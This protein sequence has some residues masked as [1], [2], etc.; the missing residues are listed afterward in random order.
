MLKEIGDVDGIQV[1]LINLGSVHNK[2]EKYSESIKLT[3]R[4]IAAAKRMKDGLA[5]IRGYQIMAEIFRKQKDFKS[6]VMYQLIYTKFYE[7][8]YQR[9]DRQQVCE[10]EHQFTIQ[11]LEKRIAD[12]Q[13]NRHK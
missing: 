8:F 5:E 9:N 6:A 11:Q 3:S 10:I 2:L 13:K 12:L 4:G 1:N 7:D